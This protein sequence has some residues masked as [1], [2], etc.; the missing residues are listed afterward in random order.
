MLHNCFTNFSIVSSKF[1]SGLQSI[2]RWKRNTT[3]SKKSLKG[4]NKERPICHTPNSRH[5]LAEDF[6]KA[7]KCAS[8]R[9]F[10]RVCDRHDGGRSLKIIYN[11]KTKRKNNTSSPTFAPSLTSRTRAPP[12]IRFSAFFPVP[13]KKGHR[14]R[15]L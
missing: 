3:C 8:I 14:P 10:P 15:V 11:N 9:N 5:L 1:C 4:K 7:S 6:I 2:Y 13:S 12:F